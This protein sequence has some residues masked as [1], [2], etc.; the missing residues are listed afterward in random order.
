MILRFL[1]DFKI[2]WWHAPVVPAT[3]EAEAGGPLEL[4]GRVWAEIAPLLQPGRDRVR[5]S[6]KEKEKRKT[7]TQKEKKKE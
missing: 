6:S 7:L 3:R 4:G 1:K 2:P 5:L